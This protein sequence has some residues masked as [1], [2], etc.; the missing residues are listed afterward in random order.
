VWRQSL[1]TAW[2]E[3]PR[4]SRRLAVGTKETPMA[5]LLWILAVVLVIAGIVTLIRG[6]VLLGILLIVVGLF[7]GPGGVSLFT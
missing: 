5:T 7:V 1:A 2:L 3:G 4:R 6:Q